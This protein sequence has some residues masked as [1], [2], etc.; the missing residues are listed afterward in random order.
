MALLLVKATLAP[1][2]GASAD[3]VTVQEEV[4]RAGMAAWIQ[5]NELGLVVAVR[6]RVADWL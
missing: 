6:L 2:E 3:R 4:P 5:F 1:P